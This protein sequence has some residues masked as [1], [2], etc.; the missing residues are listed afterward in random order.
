MRRRLLKPVQFLKTVLPGIA[1][2]VLFQL[3]IA[4]THG[5]QDTLPAT[6]HEAAAWLE[7][8]HCSVEKNRD[9]AVTHVTIGYLRGVFFVGDLEVFPELESIKLTYSSRLEDSHMSGIARLESLKKISF[10]NCDSLTESS[11]A[12]LHYLPQLEEVEM[13]SCDSIF[14]L[15]AL[16]SCES[17]KRIKLSDCDEFNFFGLKKIVSLPQLEELRLQNNSALLDEH[18]ALLAEAKKLTELNFNGCTS[19]TDEG[20][21]VLAGLPALKRLNLFRCSGVTGT[22]L[23]HAPEDLEYLV[24][25]KT[26]F[27]VDGLQN[28]TRFKKLKELYFGHD[29]SFT[30]EALFAV[31]T[32]DQLEKV[33]LD[34][35][36]ITEKHLEKMAGCRNLNTLYL[37]DCGQVTG[38]GLEHLVDCK[39]LEVLELI[40]CDRIDSPD[41]KAVSAFTNLKHLDLS[42][43]RVR[44]EGFAELAGLTQLERLNLSDCKW[45]DDASLSALCGLKS[46][47]RL[48]LD[49]V[50]RI[51]DEGLQSLAEMPALESLSISNNRLITGTGF[52]SF[53]DD[54]PLN[55]LALRSLDKLS[56]EGLQTLVHLGNLERLEIECRFLQ[57]AHLL[58]MQGIP[59]L[60][61]FDI[62]DLKQVDQE[63]YR[64]FYRSLPS[65]DY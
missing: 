4:C 31:T 62:E 48:T 45:V 40:R 11:L 53:A 50:K 51:T 23:Q 52:A 29:D 19:I 9:G 56:P 17:L 5:M 18:L 27:N 20:L 37:T 39:T 3:T 58:A 44:T 35:V 28:L 10:D 42:G 15:A 7:K 55:T 33:A 57:D 14:S 30:E 54:A 12:V 6:P 38:A 32:S 2:C 59:K 13:N 1:V 36:G 24:L 63:V 34:G 22:A 43:T 25:R 8:N 49:D 46:L 26:A 60:K 41:M 64:K 47:K 61:T 65:Y 16:R 21:A